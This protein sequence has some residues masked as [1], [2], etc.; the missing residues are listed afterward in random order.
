MTGLVNV[1]L[2]KSTNVTEACESDFCGA[3]WMYFAGE[4]ELLQHVSIWDP[5]AN[6]QS[7]WR[8]QSAA[9]A[10]ANARLTQSPV[11]TN[12][13][14]NPAITVTGLNSFIIY[15]VAETIHKCQALV[16]ETWISPVS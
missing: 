4:I 9:F 15:K 8:Q 10:S 13:I 6:G 16:N 2:G 12:R 7:A 5:P 14:A 11:V 1:S 3:D